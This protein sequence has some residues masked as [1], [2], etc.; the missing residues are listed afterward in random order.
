MLDVPKLSSFPFF[1]ELSP[2]G[3]SQLRAATSH[4]LLAPQ[5]KVI[6]RGDEVGGVYLVEAGALRVYYVSA[7][8]REGTLYWVDAGQSCILALNCLFSRLVYPAWVETD[9]VETRVFIISGEVYRRL[10]LVEPALQK[11]TFETLTTR[12]FELM[13][14]M[15]ETASL[16]L[17]QRVAAFLLRRSVNGQALEVTHEQIAHHLGSSREVV[18]RV[19]R[20]LAARGAIKLSHRSVAI[21]DSA[22]L[23]GTVESFLNP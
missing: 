3:Q 10:Y 20:N 21:E 1:S 5:T 8:G 22:K 15:Q 19:L 18:S 9:Q 4:V 12:L 7:E 11:F 6:Q 23:R 13:T 2:A 16:G 17:E 14:L